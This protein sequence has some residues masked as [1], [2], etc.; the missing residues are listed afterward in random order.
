MK[1]VKRILFL[2]LCFSALA[3]AAFA[4]TTAFTYQGRLTDAG[5]PPSANYDFEFRLI[6][7]GGG[8][9]TVQF[10]P[11]V[12]VVSGVFNIPLDFGAGVFQG[13]PR[14][15]EIAVRPAG[16]GGFMTLNPRQPS[17]S[18][19]YAIRSLNS[20]N[21]DNSTRL[22]GIDSARLVQQDAG[23]NVSIGGNLS[24]AG[25]ATYDTVNATTQYNLGG[26]RILSAAGN[27]NLFAGLGAG[28]FNTTGYDNA[29]FGQG[30]GQANTIGYQNSFFGK[31]RDCE[32][33]PAFGIHSSASTRASRIRPEPI[34]SLSARQPELKIEPAARTLLSEFLPVRRTRL[35]AIRF[36]ERAADKKTRSARTIRFSVTSPVFLT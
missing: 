25:T 7:A 34:T 22:G 23:G 14:S 36:S 6:G 28:Q 5:L 1:S 2:F 31:G 8:I 19:P 13:E 26:Q 15:L 16:G 35:V 30:A 27:G 17:L 10:A 32:T 18:A 29:F 33:R 12:P 11:N 3:G 20:S 4:S 24:V 9:I 21:S